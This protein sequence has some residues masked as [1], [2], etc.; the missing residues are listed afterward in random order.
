MLTIFLEEWLFRSIDEYEFKE[1]II[2]QG[3]DGARERMCIKEKILTRDGDGPSL[4]KK[5]G[6]RENVS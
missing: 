6:Q 5:W 4:V 1:K 3:E 2:S